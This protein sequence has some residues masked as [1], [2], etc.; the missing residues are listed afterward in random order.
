MASRRPA[1]KARS[2]PASMARR[3]RPWLL[4]V[5]LSVAT[6]VAYLPVW[7]G[8]P[9]WDDDAHLT[10]ASL[11]S[12][13]GLGRIWTDFQVTQQYYPI[14]NTAFWVMNRLWGQN[15][16]G[17]H[18]VNIFLH[19][20]SAFLVAG[21]LRRWSLPGAA[22][23]AVIFALHPIQ[24]ESVA[25]MSE[26]KNTL[27]GVFYLLAAIVYLKFDTNRHW[28]QYL[29]ALGLFVLALGSKTVTATLPAALLIVLWWRRGR[30]TWRQDVLPLIPFFVTGLAAGAGTAWLEVAW[31][32]AKGQSFDLT[33]V[34]RT[35]LAGRAAWFYAGKVLWP[36]DLIFMYPRWTIDQSVWWQYLFP[37]ALAGALVFLWV[38]RA[39]ARGPL[40]AALY[41]CGT[42]FP[43]LGFVNVFPFRY[44]FVAD[45]FQ[46]L[47]SLGVI[48]PLSVGLV[49]AARRWRFGVSDQVIAAAVAVPLL[50]L[51]FRQS[52][53]Y[54]DAETLYRSTIAAN[55]DSLL[56]RS[57][58]SSL[59]LDG[60]A[61]R[62]AEAEQQA[63]EALRID[64][65]DA[66]AHN[67]LGLAWQ[68]K[69]R[70]ADAVREHQ[71]AIRLD[72]DLAAAHYDLGIALG[73]LGNLDEAAAAYDESLR[74]FP[75]QPEVLNN[76][77]QLRARQGRFPEGVSSV[78][79][80]I[81]LA[82][83]SPDLR[84]SL[85]NILQSSHDYSAAIVAYDEALSIRPGWGEA[86]HNKALALRALGRPDESVAA[87]LEAER[88]MPGVAQ[89]ELSFA[90]L[91]ESMN[92][93]DE[94]VTHYER[95]LESRDAPRPAEIHNA[96]GILLARSGKFQAAAAHFEAALRLEPD[97]AAAR[98]NLARVQ[99]GGR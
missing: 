53:Q 56:A 25:W 42:L 13:E 81:R 24:V 64:P 76:L 4:L 10:P 83:G 48:V 90:K 17:Y 57:N 12:W 82:P 47:A 80:A 71:E 88:L 32:G 68:R 51:T 55:P 73:A 62:W 21:I 94:A 45:H 54:V 20:L 87:F 3:E 39:R 70:Y 6:L 50:V 46:Y 69:G 27:S 99:R 59:L 38:I 14:V 75:S 5:V 63:A 35:M 22:I 44:S 60:P 52:R 89:V 23:A 30:V 77:G 37:L 86:W 43:A 33:W 79:E 84:M 92:R 16:L 19:A 85:A 96:V 18:L 40:A 29:L 58:L 72:P 7:H 97:F 78:R 26:L 49:L 91:L 36:V 11:A 93:L 65:R 41:F 1:A 61:D 15:T 67:N 9:L 98:A 66:S 74:I 2:I 95:A 31:V 28:R 8:A 34:E